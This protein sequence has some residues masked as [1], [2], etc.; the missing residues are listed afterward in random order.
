M[1]PSRP[2]QRRASVRGAPPTLSL[3]EM[4]S[5]SLG[6]A[7]HT[8]TAHARALPRVSGFLLLQII[9]WGLFFI[10]RAFASARLFPEYFWSYMGPRLGIVLSYAAATTVIHIIV[11]RFRTW[12][13]AQRLLLTLALCALIMY[14]MHVFE[15]GLTR[16]V[17]PDWPSERFL[18]YLTQFGWVL[19]A[20]AGYYYAQDHAR[21]V[22]RQAAA[23]SQAQ[24]FAHAAQMKMLRYQLNPHF[25]FNSLNAIS[26]LVLENRNKEAESMLLRLSRFLRHTIDTDPTQLAKLGDEAHVQKLYLEMEAVRFGD[27]L[28]VDCVVP[29][30][31]HEC[32]VPSLLL[33]PI[34]ENAIKHGVSKSALAAASLS[35]PANRMAA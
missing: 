35:T 24:A 28:T 16:T 18:D 3:T 26:T 9:F 20:W 2:I 33:Q 30:R 19:L 31:L 6:P 1:R 21:E 5:S 4:D 11:V 13:P 32:L 14:P 27:R 15:G 25:L 12:S 17:A 10:I 23:L 7:A 29:K 34:V 22:E 8:A